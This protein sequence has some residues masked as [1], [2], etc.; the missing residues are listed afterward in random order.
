MHNLLQIQKVTLKMAPFVDDG[1]SICYKINYSNFAHII[2]QPSEMRNYFGSVKVSVDIFNNTE[3]Y[4]FIII[5]FS[6]TV[7]A[8]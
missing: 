5:T 3:N 1:I 4:L 8:F 6:G 2:W 7:K